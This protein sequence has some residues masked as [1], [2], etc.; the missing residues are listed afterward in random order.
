M[1]ESAIK[2][3]SVITALALV[4]LWVPMSHRFMSGLFGLYLVI[5][6]AVP[7]F[8]PKLIGGCVL[9][10]CWAVVS[11]SPLEVSL[12]SVAGPPRIVPLVMGTLSPAGIERQKRG[13]FVSGG[14]VVSGFEPRW[15]VVW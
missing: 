12:R 14:C 7:R 15:V 5:V 1:P 8:R 9:A 13:E 6:F 3:V 4:V 11:A 2:V 10:S